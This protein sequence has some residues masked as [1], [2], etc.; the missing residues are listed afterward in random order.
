MENEITAPRDGVVSELSV[1]PGQPVT[2]GQVI[3]VVTQDGLDRVR[4]PLCADISREN[5]EPLAATASRIDNW[6]LVEYRGLWSR[7]A[8]PGSGSLDQVKEHL[9]SRSH[10]PARAP[11]LRPPP[12]PAGASAAARLRRRLDDRAR[13]G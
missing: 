2:T 6:F 4:R 12:R 7:D 9:A 3:C 11:A 5:A 13:R 8:L 1:A 10:G